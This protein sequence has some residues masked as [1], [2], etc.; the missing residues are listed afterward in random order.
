MSASLNPH[1]SSITHSQSSVNLFS[2]HF[3]YNSH[4][5]YKKKKK[6]Y[7]TY[8]PSSI[9]CFPAPWCV[10]LA[11]APPPPLN[12]TH[13][14]SP[15]MKRLCYNASAPPISCTGLGIITGFAS[16]PQY[17]I[18]NSRKHF[19]FPAF[20]FT[21]TFFPLCYLIGSLRAVPGQ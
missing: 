1:L 6:Q 18:C 9:P 19:S 5:H 16:F 3:K 14:Q 21:H 4:N 2:P 17:V 12:S 13:F 11:P 15:T 10:T 7:T 8:S 20:Q